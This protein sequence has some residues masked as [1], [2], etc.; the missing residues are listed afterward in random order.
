MDPALAFGL[1]PELALALAKL[2]FA[3][4]RGG[5]VKGEIQLSFLAPDL[6]HRQHQQDNTGD[7]KT[8]FL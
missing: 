5:I 8:P 3:R 4:G 1:G 6:H 2:D 7:K